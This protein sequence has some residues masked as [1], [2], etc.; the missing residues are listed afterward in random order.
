L[1]VV[2]CTTLENVKG[3]QV[4][5]E[6]KVSEYANILASISVVGQQQSSF[7]TN[8]SPPNK[9]AGFN[10]KIESHDS[11]EDCVLVRDTS[12]VVD[13]PYKVVDSALPNNGVATLDLCIEA[14]LKYKEEDDKLEEMATL[15]M[16]GDSGKMIVHK[17]NEQ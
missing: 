6:T 9:E 7:V 10:A 14:R 8:F 16:S 15:L 17:F 11:D 13:T 12:D 2:L 1:F 3:F 4:E 5:G